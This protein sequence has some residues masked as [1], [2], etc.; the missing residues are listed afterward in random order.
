MPLLSNGTARINIAENPPQGGFSW[1]YASTYLM[2]VYILSVLHAFVIG[3]VVPMLTGG[4]LGFLFGVTR[5]MNVINSFG[6]MLTV[7]CSV[8]V[9]VYFSSSLSARLMQTYLADSNETV[10]SIFSSICF[11]IALAVLFIG[12]PTAVAPDGFIFMVLL[13]IAATTAI[14]YWRTSR[15]LAERRFP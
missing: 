8:A 2:R 15:A 14:F 11:G 5:A 1:Y 3:V 12:R 4:V 6:I 10:F 13:F 7:F 9:L